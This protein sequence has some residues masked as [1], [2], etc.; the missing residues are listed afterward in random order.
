MS[1]EY[2]LL[3]AWLSYPHLKGHALCLGGA[4]HTHSPFCLCLPD[5][6]LHA[7]LGYLS[8]YRK[9]IQAPF[10]IFPGTELVG[11]LRNLITTSCQG[12]NPITTSPMVRANPF[13]VKGSKTKRFQT[14]DVPEFCL[15]SEATRQKGC[16]DLGLL[17]LETVVMIYC[18]HHTHKKE[19]F[20]HI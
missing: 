12:E 16:S 2:L 10:L 5:Q 15:P 9:N 7:C 1:K 19:E 6:S 3:H 11:L 4:G 20:F 8:S 18:Y 14:G 13:D 17:G